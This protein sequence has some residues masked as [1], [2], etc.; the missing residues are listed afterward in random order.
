MTTVTTV[1]TMWIVSKQVT[2]DKHVSVVISFCVCV[3][4]WST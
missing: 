4:E 2:L 1:V 3:P